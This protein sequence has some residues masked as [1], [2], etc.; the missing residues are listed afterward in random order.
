MEAESNH[1]YPDQMEYVPNPRFR[2]QVTL[3]HKVGQNGRVFGT[4]GSNDNGLYGKGGYEHNIF[5]DHRGTLNGQVSGTRVLGPYGGS[6]HVG[7]AL[8]WKNDR[9]SASLEASKMIHGPT[10]INAAAGARWPIGRNGDL[11]AQGFYSHTQGFGRDYGGRLN[12]RYRF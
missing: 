2:R 5:N 8:N 11:S 3:D 6:S 10:S 7:G 12:Y 4:L 9:A 1:G